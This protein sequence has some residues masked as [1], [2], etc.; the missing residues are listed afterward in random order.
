MMIP[1]PPVMEADAD[2]QDAVVQTPYRSAG[3]PPERLEGLVLL[4]ELAT[5]EL[6]D[7]ADQ[8]PGW[9]VAAA[10]ARVLVDRA[11]GDAL[12]RPGG[13]ALAVSGLGRAR[14]PGV[15]GTGARRE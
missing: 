14:P 4:E 3:I 2:L 1:V 15:R 10:R 11:T 13:L 5:V 12:W 9:R 8:R 7:A 6:F